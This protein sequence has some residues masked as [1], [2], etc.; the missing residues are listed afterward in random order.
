MPLNVKMGGRPKP[1]NS[2]GIEILSME[3][4]GPTLEKS[5]RN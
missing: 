1:L 4:A 3:I 5:A 2:I